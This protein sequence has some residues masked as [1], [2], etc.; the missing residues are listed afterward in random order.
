[1]PALRDF[2]AAMLPASWKDAVYEHDVLSSFD[3]L[4][5]TLG[6]AEPDRV[7]M[8]PAGEVNLY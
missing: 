2:R 4:L 7:E 5:V 3:S 8:T 1:M 6:R